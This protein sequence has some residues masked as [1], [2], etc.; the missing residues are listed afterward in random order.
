MKQKFGHWS[1]ISHKITPFCNLDFEV[2]IQILFIS[3]TF[4]LVALVVL[5]IAR[6]KP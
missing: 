3:E 1:D 5:K 2:E 4:A 6:D